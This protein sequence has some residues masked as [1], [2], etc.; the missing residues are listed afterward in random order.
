M[1]SV[2]GNNGLPATGILTNGVVV[3]SD[4]SIGAI[5]LSK[6]HPL[7]LRA[8]FSRV[9]DSVT[10]IYQDRDFHPVWFNQGSQKSQSE[11]NLKDLV[12]ILQQAS[13][14]GLKPE[15]YDAERLK[16]FIVHQ[17]QDADTTASYDVALTV[18]LVRFLHELRQGRVEPR[19]ERIP[20][21]IAPKPPLNLADLLAKHKASA[22]LPE[23]VPEF[24]PKS[25]Q[26]QQLK[27]ILNQLQSPDGASNDDWQVFKLSRTLRPGDKHP[28]VAA[29]RQRL[30]TMGLGDDIGELSN[31]LY[32]DALATAI[33]SF[34]SQHGLKADAVIGPATAALLT[35]TPQEKIDQIELA[36]ERARWI[37]DATD[38]PLIVVNIPAFELWAFNSAD[39]QNPLNMKVIV[40]KSPDNQTPVLWEEMKY[41][42]FMPYWNI[43]KTIFTK[44]ILPKTVNNEGYLASQDIELIRHNNRDDQG[45][46]S[47]IRARQ[48]PGKKNPLGRVKFV[49]PNT[50]DVYLHDTPSQAAFNR[51]RRDL[52]HG[53]V[54]VSDPERLAE[55]VLGDQQ[56]W[57]KETIRQAMSAAKTRHVALKRTVPVL[58]YYGTTFVDHE[59]KLRFYPDVYGQDEQLKRALN[60][61]HSPAIASLSQLAKDTVTNNLPVSAR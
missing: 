19:E 56:G 21:H 2:I 52:S 55:F 45:G 23:L 41:L 44:E 61:V 20:V 30:K 4:N 17:S 48:R 24:E 37:P 33:K 60:K 51:S 22:T 31:S 39:D 8:D 58:F 36:M 25:R 46:G 1:L 28:D 49:F 5:L 50:A 15:H 32:D 59:N 47:Y 6:R 34:Q 43:P 11:K 57:D 12:D 26:Y 13:S 14:H 38:G 29:V 35:T 7:L 27:H 3:P 16:G 10:Q 54:R 18:S 40:G 53:C 9:A 42:E